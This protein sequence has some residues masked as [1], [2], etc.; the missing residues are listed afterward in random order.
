MLVHEPA[1]P[2]GP[3]RSFVLLLLLCVGAAISAQTIHFHSAS[4]PVGSAHCTLCEVGE[5][6]LTVS[7]VST[8]TP[9]HPVQ[10][11]EIANAEATLQFVDGSNL[12][13]RAPP[14]S[15]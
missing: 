5:V 12:S 13:V 3:Y 7:I 8:V 6:P 10:A 14:L 11:V 2:K 4:E 15:K 1:D 9:G